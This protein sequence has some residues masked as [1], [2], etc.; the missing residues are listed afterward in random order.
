M[1]EVEREA[2]VCTHDIDCWQQLRDILLAEM[3][4]AQIVSTVQCNSYECTHVVRLIG[5]P[6]PALSSP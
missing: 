3:T 5:F 1:T 2:D 6:Q 4:A